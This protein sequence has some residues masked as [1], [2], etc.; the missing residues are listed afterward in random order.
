MYRNSRFIKVVSV[1]VSIF[2]MVNNV[3]WATPALRQKEP[4]L[5]GLA[6]ARD[7]GTGQDIGQDLTAKPESPGS[8]VVTGLAH[9]IGMKLNADP[10]R[11]TCLAVYKGDIRQISKWVVANSR[12][13]KDF[14]ALYPA[15]GGF[16]LA[17]EGNF[18]TTVGRFNEMAGLRQ[19]RRN[20]L[21]Q[22][23][24][25]I[26]DRLMKAARLGASDEDIR[27]QQVD[28][29]L[30]SMV[31]D[32]VE[33]EFF[34]ITQGEDPADQASDRIRI[35]ISDEWGYRDF[36]VCLGDLEAEFSGKG[37]L[38][39]R[40][41]NENLLS[42]PGKVG[43]AHCLV[44]IKDVN[45]IVYVDLLPARGHSVP[46]LLIP[47]RVG[48]ETF[49]A[50]ALVDPTS[51]FLAAVIERAPLTSSARATWSN[52]ALD[53]SKEQK[54]L[55]AL[56]KSDVRS[57]LKSTG[58]LRI[59]PL[60]KAHSAGSIDH[61]ATIAKI[62]E[63]I[64]TEDMVGQL[65]DVASL[66]DELTADEL[67]DFIGANLSNK[68]IKIGLDKLYNR[69]GWH[70]LRIK[71]MLD[72]FDEIIDP[73]IVITDAIRKKHKYV[74]ISGM[75]GSRLGIDTILEIFGQPEGLQIFTLGTT[76]AGRVTD[77]I[78][79]IT[80]DAGSLKAGLEDTLF[81]AMS[82]SGT[83]T[84]TLSHKD[85][86]GDRFDECELSIQDH[87]L[88]ITDRDSP[89]EQEAIERNIPYAHIQPNHR[90]DIGG[91]FTSPATMIALLAYALRKGDDAK[92]AIRTLL[93]QAV[94]MNRAQDVKEDIFIRFGAVLYYFASQ[95]KGDKLTF[96]LP[97]ELKA[98][99]PWA[100]Q[101]FEESLGK[102]AM[103]ADES[104]KE[105]EKGITIIYDEN[106]TPGKLKSLNEN[107]RF[108]LRITLDGV[109][110]PQQA[111]WDHIS[112]QG[113]P[114]YEIALENKEQVGGLQL[115]L[116]RA[117]ATVA[118]LW[119]GISFVT[120][121]TVQDNKK[122][123]I[124][125]REQVA[126]TGQAAEIPYEPIASF[127]SL[128][129][130]IEPLIEVGALTLA[131]IE[132]A[133]A[134]MNTGSDNAPAIYAA[135]IRILQR[136]NSFEVGMLAPWT[137]MD[138]SFRAVMEEARD[139]IFTTDLKVCSKLAIYPD[140]NHS[141]EQNLEG[142]RDVFFSTFLLGSQM[143]QPKGLPPYEPELLMQ[144]AV[145]TA[146]SIVGKGRKLIFIATDG[147]LS[148]AQ[149]DIKDFF[150]MV[151]DYLDVLKA[152]SAGEDKAINV[153]V[154]IGGHKVAV[155]LVD[156][157]GTLLLRTPF[158]IK[159][160]EV[161]GM[162]PDTADF[163]SKENS[164]RFVDEV[165]KLITQALAARGVSISDISAIGISF[166]GPIDSARGI[167][168]TPFPAPNTPFDEYNIIEAI[169]SRVADTLGRDGIEVN[170]LND[171]QAARMGELRPGGTLHSL[172]VEDGSVMIAGGGIN[173]D[174]GDKRVKEMGH[175]LIPTELV[176]QFLIDFTPSKGAYTH[177]G[178]ITLGDHPKDTSGNPFE[179]DLEDICSG[180]NLAKAFAAQ[181]MTGGGISASA[182]IK[183]QMKIHML[184]DAE[185]LEQWTNVSVRNL[186]RLLIKEGT[187]TKMEE[188]NR[189]KAVDTLLRSITE[190]AINGDMLSRQLIRETGEKIGQAL[191][192][193]I[194]AYKNEPFV[195]HIVLVS[196]VNE[197]FGKG[198][199]PT[200]DTDDDTYIRAIRMAV[201]KELVAYYD[202]DSGQAADVANG[203]IRSKLTYQREFM[204][205]TPPVKASSAGVIT[206]S[207]FYVTADS[208]RILALTDKAMTRQ[209]TLI[210]IFRDVFGRGPLTMAE[211]PG[212]DNAQGEHVDYPDEQFASA[213]THLFSM[214][215]ALQNSFV[216]AIA[217]RN[218]DT[219]RIAHAD[220][221]QMIEFSIDKLRELQLNAQAVRVTN[222]PAAQRA[223]PVWANHTMG[224]LMQAVSQDKRIS[225]MD[226]L[227][228][229][230]IPFGAGLSNSA[231]NC[232]AVTMALSDAYSWCLSEDEVIT[233]ARDGEHDEFVGSTCGWL[234]QI[235][236]VKSKTGYFAMIDYATNEVTYFKSNLPPTLQRVLVNTNVPHDL[237]AT[238]YNDRNKQELPRAH[239]ILRVLLPD[240]AIHGSTSLTLAEINHLIKLFDPEAP[241][242]D[243]T[244]AGVA[245]II[246]PQQRNKQES[247]DLPDD[248][249]L[250]DDFA[251]LNYLM[252]TST[253][254]GHAMEVLPRHAELTLQQSFA[255]C[256][257]RMRHQLTSALRTPLTGE[258]AKA[259]NVAAF[260]ELI[261]AEG[262][263]LRESGD[264]QITGLNGAQDSLLDI[265]F[266]V[267]RR[268]GITVH[269]RMEGGG[270]GGN[271]GFYVDRF[272]ELKY[273]QWQRQ[274]TLEYKAWV[275][276]VEGLKQRDIKA[277]F[278]EPKL[279]E[280]AKYAVKANSAGESLDLTKIESLNAEA[281]GQAIA[282][283]TGNLHDV[284]THSQ[285]AAQM[286]NV[287][288][289]G[290]IAI[291]EDSL[292]ESQKDIILQ[293]YHKDSPALH[294]LERL[295]GLTIRLLSQLSADDIK[296]GLIMISDTEVTG[297]EKAKRIGIKHGGLKTTNDYM[298]LIP[299]IFIAKLLLVETDAETI[300]RA[301]N[302]N[303]FYRSIFGS[304]VTVRAILEFLNRGFLLLKVHLFIFAFQL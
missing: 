26:A 288:V 214:G 84:E 5:R 219:I 160:R 33:I 285:L 88:Y 82:K 217:K 274:V 167:V 20:L 268:L 292:P 14:R 92:E 28:F 29:G 188:K 236:V 48:D 97:E 163:T 245:S 244:E 289:E 8:S 81:I 91:R 138:E 185:L 159:W 109:A 200:P 280:G 52:Y 123:I 78:D 300:R 40:D 131:E 47:G 31:V 39:A 77:I 208:S 79:A 193:F 141:F 216:A 114:S 53:W 22:D 42:Y 129:L 196:G 103:L 86:F 184:A 62:L 273:S 256:L 76:D 304:P 18:T 46:V 90:V 221:M 66:P 119:D 51:S 54:G 228:T 279:S 139:R 63:R 224:V 70:P 75:G 59:S 35:L 23:G 173:I 101:L 211:A 201:M 44:E 209:S 269:G 275:E 241:E 223:I 137:Q 291:N 135:I 134:E 233:F 140:G 229:S 181:M 199:D 19:L 286:H 144:Q 192:A 130:Y 136:K 254:A 106:L 164:D 99:A 206:K 205:F 255:L 191:A 180:P 207:A 36:R 32:G 302:T 133:L 117:V 126:E 303:D 68:F 267:G 21:N 202:F 166:A 72:N 74:I 172:G 7:E 294:E 237:V 132:D 71:E 104:T 11:L 38:D 50:R 162:S 189:S 6:A 9:L 203:I 146:N 55:V 142:G 250:L 60:L 239:N 1:A 154:S 43:Q 149:D 87:L 186:L 220:T 297:Y 156:S 295:T 157:D 58:L 113:Y 258:A 143:R 116:A 67:A 16:S 10:V 197:N 222:L 174:S 183:G 69:L 218:D 187:F 127:G 290:T 234:D 176:R 170:I 296:G 247:M 147:M 145:G 212:R 95:H 56:T 272:D 225:G 182:A 240:K 190:A 283:S 3:S 271:V 110:K 150:S 179:G 125:V 128:R 65:K 112:E 252:P 278:I 298:P 284:L 231:A 25:Y 235:L 227:L 155:D 262:R 151:V 121:K 83:T 115:G 148:S 34:D 165:I 293:I 178:H 259:G 215:G 301:L 37:E 107:D 195:R 108:F 57:M 261:D 152:S 213:Q 94:A 270:G 282:A 171:C 111:L 265:G 277:S 263:S 249:S 194:D 299:M 49:L 30:S 177:V 168:G 158:D 260:G 13:E 204:A 105:D 61:D 98:I 230:N 243:L 124:A 102:T 24:H 4:A 242:V 17:E 85:Y 287:V 169:Q 118:W 153:A 210:G 89:M 198:V 175:Q 161:L 45:D 96:I 246:G 232:V 73:L 64:E 248:E 257:R 100:E 80:K 15:D 253:S 12:Q 122:A 2:F 266:D 226:I 276:Q 120:Q 238:E 27:I 41:V 251:R 93:Q 264:Y 281:L